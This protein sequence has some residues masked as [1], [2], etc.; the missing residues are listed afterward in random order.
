M[1][2]DKTKFTTGGVV[3]PSKLTPL[4][5]GEHFIPT[6]STLNNKLHW[7]PTAHLG[8]NK[9]GVLMQRWIGRRFTEPPKFEWRPIQPIS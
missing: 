6:L 2:N 3:D 8:Y 4:L 5:V 1:S 7:E 9:D